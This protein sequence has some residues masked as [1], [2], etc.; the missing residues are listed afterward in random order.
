MRETSY[1]KELASGK[2]VIGDS[3][4]KIE[5]IFVKEKK[6]EEI[7]FSWWKNG[8]MIPRPPDGTPEEWLI[9]F[10][11]ALKN[12]VFPKDFLLELIRLFLKKW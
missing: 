2:I 9:A 4:L 12:G 11:D 3:E 8:K 7:R 10:E 6:Q 1:A 5:R